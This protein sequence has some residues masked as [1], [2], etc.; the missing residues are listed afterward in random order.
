MCSPL[1][2]GLMAKADAASTAFSAPWFIC[3]TLKV[4]Y[5]CTLFALFKAADAVAVPSASAGGGVALP[6]E[7][8]E[9]ADAVSPASEKTGQGH[10]PV[11][12]EGADE[13][14]ASLLA[15]P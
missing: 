9:L 3:G 7:G 12:D 5:D 10:R 4:V 11:E 8:D 2:L 13:G 6:T 1:L 14:T 15:P